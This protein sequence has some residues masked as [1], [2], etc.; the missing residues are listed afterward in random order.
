M[1]ALTML[2]V[3]AGLLGS[4]TVMAQDAPAMDPKKAAEMQ[5][6]MDAMQRAGTPGPEHARLKAMAGT[7]DVATRYWMEPGAEPQE[8]NG[9][10]ELKMILGDRY[11][12]QEFSGN[13]MGQPYSGHGLMGYDNVKKKYFSLWAD[14]MSTGLYTGEGTADK[15]GRVF[16]MATQMTDPV[17]G[18]VQK[19]KD[20]MTLNP[21]GSMTSEMWAPARKGGKMFKMMELR[22][23]KK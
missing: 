17:T 21:D 18:K 10:A 1:R 19:G 15:E 14:S 2:V 16:T 5:K 22:Y 6:V 20:V 13:I 11:Q 4:A 7:Y 8:M 3:V 23:T 12:V 9:K